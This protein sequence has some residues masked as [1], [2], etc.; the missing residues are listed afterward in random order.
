MHGPLSLFALAGVLCFATAAFAGSPVMIAPGDA[1][2]SRAGDSF[3]SF[4]EEWMGRALARS[5]RDRKAPRAH[6]RS[7]GLLFTYRAVDDAFETELRPTGR[8]TS[9]YV[10]VLRYT[11]HTYTCDDVHASRCRVTSSLPLTELF[12][13]RGG[14][15]TY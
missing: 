11:E 3:E 9:P 8:P 7:L 10:G 4:A 2:A 1:S 6:Q 13:Y 14:R 12:R 5:E 15:G